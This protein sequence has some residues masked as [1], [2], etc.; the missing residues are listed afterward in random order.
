M[1]TAKAAAFQRDNG[2]K[3]QFLTK[4]GLAGATSDAKRPVFSTS[5]AKRPVFLLKI[6]TGSPPEY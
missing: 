5:D 1:T 3:E 6:V 4:P 2:P